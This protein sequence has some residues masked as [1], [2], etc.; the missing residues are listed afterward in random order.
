M[1]RHITGH[2]E[3]PN[4]Q[5]QHIQPQNNHLTLT[6]NVFFNI[7]FILDNVSVNSSGATRDTSP[8]GN[9]ELNLLLKPNLKQ[10]INIENDSKNK[11]RQLIKYYIRN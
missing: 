11:H 1:L 6:G 3:Q 7:L 2:N 5:Q 9:S 8:L 4:V 10:Y